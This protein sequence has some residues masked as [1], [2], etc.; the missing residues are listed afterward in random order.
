MRR[1]VAAECASASSRP[2]ASTVIAGPSGLASPA[3]GSEAMKPQPIAGMNSGRSGSTSSS[4]ARSKTSFVA[5]LTHSFNATPPQSATGFSIF[6]P[7]ATLERNVR[8]T[9]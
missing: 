1:A 6:R 7:F 4:S 9:A 5:R 8:T 3:S 2:M